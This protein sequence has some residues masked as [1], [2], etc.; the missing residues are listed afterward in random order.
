MFYAVLSKV[1]KV[2]DLIK[3]HFNVL[4]LDLFLKSVLHRHIFFFL[5]YISGGWG[6]GILC[7]LRAFYV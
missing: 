2:F 4:K 7:L 6:L 5:K 3:N 1:T